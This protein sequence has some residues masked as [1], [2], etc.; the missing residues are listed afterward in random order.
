MRP[1][2]RGYMGKECS[3]FLV[4]IKSYPNWTNRAEFDV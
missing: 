1:F 4:I 2:A 3:D